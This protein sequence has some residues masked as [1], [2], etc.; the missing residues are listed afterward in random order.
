M[1]LVFGPLVRMKDYLAP[2]YGM[3]PCVMVWCDGWH[4]CRREQ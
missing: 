1:H 3:V 4:R 2:I